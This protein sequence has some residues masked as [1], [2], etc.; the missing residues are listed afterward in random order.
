[1]SR[2]TRRAFVGSAA[3]LAACGK[4]AESQPPASIPPLK[5]VAPFPVG[6]CVQAGQLDDPAFAA[7]IGAQV[8]QLTPEWELK[9]EYVVQ[10]DGGLR[11]DAPDRIADFATDHGMRFFGHTLV[12]YAEKPAWFV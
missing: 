9:M 3:A 8:S 5:S 11:F 1:M 7:L 6:T 2:L 10:P 12:W 4:K